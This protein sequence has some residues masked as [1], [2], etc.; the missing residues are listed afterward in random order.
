[1][2]HAYILGVD[3]GG[4]HL[5]AVLV[6]QQTQTFR[7]DSYIRIRIDSHGS[8]DEII[9]TWCNA[10]A[11]IFE[12]YEISDRRVG[13]A[14]PGPFNYE[15]GISLIKELDKYDSLYGLN[16]KNILAERLHMSPNSILMMNDAAGF[17]RG[18]MYGGCG[19]GFRDAIGVTLGTG[20]GT[21][22]HHGVTTTDANLGPSSFMESIADNYFSTR[23]FVKRYAQL[24]GI[25]VK[26]VKE[27]SALHGVDSDAS[28]VFTEFVSNF[29]LFLSNFIMKESPEIVILGGNIM[30]CS[31]LFLKNLEQ[32]LKSM[33]IP[34][35]IIKAQLGEKAAILGAANLFAHTTVMS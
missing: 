2:K 5:T 17:L 24:T 1:M 26:D 28:L 7:S 19:K 35:P 32:K 21:A 18:E 15:K 23:W 30:H 14:M 16:I 31:D 22:I 4:S 11:S 6:S 33:Q 29:S 8:A 12:K 10:I 20:T 9:T 27:L 25:V 13:I 3:I 34:T